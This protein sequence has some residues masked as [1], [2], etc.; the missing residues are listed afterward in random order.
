MTHQHHLMENLKSLR[1][2]GL[3]DTLELRLEQAQKQQLGYVDFLTLLIQD[4]LE[5]RVQSK[6]ERQMR[7]ACFP[8]VKTLEEFDFSFNPAIDRRRIYDLATCRFIEKKENLCLCGPVGVGKSHL[9]LALGHEAVRRGF[10]VRYLTVRRLFASLEAARAD[11]SREKLLKR[12]LHNDCLII[13]DFGLKALTEN[14]ADDFYEIV[15]DAY[16]QLSL[17][18]TSNRTVEEWMG[19]FPDPLQVNSLMDR[20]CHNA[21][22]LEWEGESYRKAK[23]T[24]KATKKREKAK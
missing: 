14:Q 4:E 17:I 3:A 24:R 7:K 22:Q 16:L 23:T 8:E 2:G 19:L 9:A 1:L 15:Y 18:L 10:E 5:R 20:L 6:F 12:Y 21:H 11:L 13:D